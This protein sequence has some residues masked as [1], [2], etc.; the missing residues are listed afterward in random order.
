M[1]KAKEEA[2][3]KLT[4]NDLLDNPPDNDDFIAIFPPTNCVS[5][6]S[7]DGSGDED[8]VDISNL[9]ASVLNAEVILED[10]EIPENELDQNKPK[11]HCRRNWIKRDLEY[12]SSMDFMEESLQTCRS[13]LFDEKAPIEILELFL[14][15]SLLQKIVDFSNIYSSPLRRAVDT[16][17]IISETSKGKTLKIIIRENLKEMHFGKWEGMKFEQ[18]GKVY[19]EEFH[20]WLSDPYNYCPIGGES[21]K[22]VKKRSVKEI[23][24]IVKENQNGSNIAIVTHGGVILSILVYWLQIPLSRWRSII[25]HQGAINIAVFEQWIRLNG[26]ESGKV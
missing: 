8:T 26:A 15:E 17:N 6:Q 21:F 18:L 3:K 10:N 7:N 5:S 23:N 24:N 14:N 20:K 13:V 2:L 19:G 22:Q 16:A 9:P 11:K 25:L 4:F 1:R 12:D